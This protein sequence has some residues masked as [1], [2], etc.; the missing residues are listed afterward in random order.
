MFYFCDINITCKIFIRITEVRFYHGWSQFCQKK[1]K[2][3]FIEFLQYNYLERSK[4]NRLLHPRDKDE[5]V[6]VLFINNI[7][8]LH[9]A[10]LPKG[11][12]VTFR[13]M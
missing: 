4:D 11:F 2:T 7:D 8:Y 5:A 12:E 3:A 13:D 6:Q 1:K 9:S 10:S